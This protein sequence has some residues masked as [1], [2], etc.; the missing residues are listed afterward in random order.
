MG[1]GDCYKIQSSIFQEKYIVESMP[2]SDTSTK[3]V[4]NK[5]SVLLVNIGEYGV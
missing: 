4:L 5:A 3:E 2:W 1:G